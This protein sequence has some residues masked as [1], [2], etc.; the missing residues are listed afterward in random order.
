MPPFVLFSFV[1]WQHTYLL[2]AL[3]EA[4]SDTFRYWCISHPSGDDVWPWSWAWSSPVMSPL[5]LT[6]QSSR[7]NRPVVSSV[8][9]C[10]LWL[11][12]QIRGKGQSDGIQLSFVSL[13]PSPAWFS[14]L[15]FPLCACKQDYLRFVYDDHVTWC[16]PTCT[17]SDLVHWNT[18]VQFRLLQAHKASEYNCFKNNIG[19]LSVAS[20]WIGVP[21]DLVKTVL[22]HMTQTLI[23]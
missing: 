3:C 14:F 18:F 15:P 7:L 13:F 5:F 23:I 16:T 20:N 11:H 12:A 1:F 19:I 9:D 6:L 10:E 8:A 17:N 21:N 4:Y 2:C 22:A